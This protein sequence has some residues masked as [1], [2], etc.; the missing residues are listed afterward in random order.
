MNQS[1]R[2]FLRQVPITAA[3]ASGIAV[4]GCLGII[5][6]DRA[7]YFSVSTI[8]VDNFDYEATKAAAENTG[9]KVDGPYSGTLKETAVGFYP[10]GIDDLDERFGADY[11]IAHA[12]FHYSPTTRVH[13]GSVRTR[14]LHSTSGMSAPGRA[15]IHSF[16]STN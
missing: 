6:S 9:Y 16:P 7:R 12:A 4:A 14:T 3:A 11:R 2:E 13:A 10:D 8:S 1:R 5:G 15:R